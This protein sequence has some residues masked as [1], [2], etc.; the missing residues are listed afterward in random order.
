MTDQ[1]SK[2]ARIGSYILMISIFGVV[3]L[4][5]LIRLLTSEPDDFASIFNDM[6]DLAFLVW[7]CF[8]ILFLHRK[9]NNTAF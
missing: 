6:M 3:F 1:L 7:F 2:R 5:D 8:M 4:Y 9:N